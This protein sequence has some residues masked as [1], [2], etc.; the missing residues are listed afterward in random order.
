MKAPVFDSYSSPNLS[1]PGF[2]GY[3]RWEPDYD[4]D[5]AAL[6]VPENYD[7]FVSGHYGG[8]VNGYGYQGYPAD[9]NHALKFPAAATGAIY[10][11]ET[12]VPEEE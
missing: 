8:Q 9:I 10:A 5:A 12:I 6:Y 1:T 2:E 4:S 11:P 3:K 7:P